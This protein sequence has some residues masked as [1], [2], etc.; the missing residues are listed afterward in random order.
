MLTLQ[1]FL[2]AITKIALRHQLILTWVYTRD[3]G[4]VLEMRTFKIGVTY[5]R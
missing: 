3:L 1:S 2:F 5:L 4:S